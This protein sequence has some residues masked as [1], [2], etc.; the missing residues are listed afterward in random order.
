M[1]IQSITGSLSAIALAGSCLLLTGQTK[2]SW[3]DA[4]V[5]KIHKDSYLVDL[6]NDVPMVTVNGKDFSLRGAGQHTD[7]VR[8]KEGAMGGQFFAAFVPSSYV[9]SNGSAHQTLRLIDSIKEDIWKKN[10]QFAWAASTSDILANKKA[11]KMSAL[12]GIEGGHAI[13]DDVRLLRRFYELGARYMTLTWTNTN[14]WCDSSGDINNPKVKHWGGLND[15]GKSIVLEMNRLGMLVDVSHIS[16]GAFWSVI[17][18]SKAPIIASHSSCRALCD[19]GRNLTDDMIQALAKKGGLMGI[20]FSCDF[21]SQKAKDANPM[22]RPEVVKE[23]ERIM[24]EV[25]DQQEAMKQFRALMAKY[26]SQTP[27]ATLEDVVAHIDHVVKLV[28]VDH[29]AIGSDFDGIGCTPDGL[30]DTSK[31]PN[32]TRALLE[33]GYTPQMIAKIYHGN[34]IRVFSAVEKTAAS[35]K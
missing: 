10:A 33:K 6:H 35:M 21:L 18:T 14:N 8:M 23:R 7:A 27:R 2:K 17:E 28:G 29:V 34:L 19:A 3:T 5:L 32:L 24:A 12:I 16:D 25:K 22:N 4:E 1:K 30:D 26:R 20:N 11:G 15:L 9:A 13:E 31:F